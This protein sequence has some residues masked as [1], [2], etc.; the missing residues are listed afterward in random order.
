MIADSAER[1]RQHRVLGLLL[2]AVGLLVA[3][4]YGQVLLSSARGRWV[5]PLRDNLIF[6]QYARALADGHPYR[7]FPSA[8][9]TTGATSHLYVMALGVLYG[10]G[11]KAER[12]AAGAFLFNALLW[13]ATL[14]LVYAIARRLFEQVAFAAALLVALTGP[15]GFAFFAGHDMGLATAL[16]FLAFYG[17]V[18]RRTVLTAFALFLLGWARPEGLLISLALVATALAAP[19]G[20]RRPGWAVAGAVGA[21]GSV[22]AL[23]FNAALTGDLAFTSMK[24]KGVIG[25]YPLHAVLREISQTLAAVVREIFVGLSETARGLYFIPL[26]GLPVLF[27]FVPRCRC[28]TVEAWLGTSAVLVILMVSASGFAGLQHDKYLVWVL[29]LA[30]LYAVAGLPAIERLLAGAIR[31]PVL[32]AIC[33]VYALV[34]AAYF[35][36][37][38]GRRVAEERAVLA[39][40]EQVRPLLPDGARVG[41]LA[42]SGIQYHLPDHEVINLSGVTHRAFGAAWGDLAAQVEILEDQ[43]ALRPDVWFLSEAERGQLATAALVGREILSTPAFLGAA[44]H[45]AFF[46]AQ[47][48]HLG[49]ADAPLTSAV[50]QLVKDRELVDEID[51][52]SPGQET[53]H[54][55]ERFT[56]LA[57][58]CLGG[59][60]VRVHFEGQDL[61]EAG[62]AILGDEEFRVDVREGKDVWVVVRTSLRL[63]A[64]SL[65]GPRHR[66]RFEVVL[67]PPVRVRVFADERPVA[68]E[69]GVLTPSHSEL[70]ERVFCIPARYVK[71]T[72]LRIRI[73]GDHIAYHY[74]FYQ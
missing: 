18:S 45:N 7:F 56:R 71:T 37:D 3:V 43:A 27:G 1:A 29:A 54:G 63:A 36:G 38:Y 5:A 16:F 21:V 35:L 19:K 44:S 65:L 51:L 4:A 15:V 72:P 62:Y 52:G 9:R 46:A 33:A 58:T 10:V 6:Y 11:L 24:G 55:Y 40:V 61:V 73:A 25:V 59:N 57:G 8:E 53:A 30:A 60:V 14:G 12:L 26:I 69:E 39:A 17:L 74:W 47:C 49:S 13:L 22:T 34:G 68:L 48:E 64:F 23:V 42:G 28:A 66:E 41:V 2:V 67:A 31:W 20:E 32:Y 70:D 50:L